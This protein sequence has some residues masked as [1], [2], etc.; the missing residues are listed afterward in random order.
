MPL[1][2]ACHLPNFSL[3]IF[4]ETPAL[5][6]LILCDCHMEFRPG[7]VVWKDRL[8]ENETRK[9]SE[10]LAVDVQT[11]LPRRLVI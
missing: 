7:I 6:L 3:R 1:N 9:F 5:L 8:H 11:S 10:D 2:S 4:A